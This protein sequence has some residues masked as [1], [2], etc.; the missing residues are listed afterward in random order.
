LV[1][2]LRDRD[3]VPGFFSALVRFSDG[4]ERDRRRRN[5]LDSRRDRREFR[6]AAV[7]DRA[8]VATAAR[9]A[10]DSLE[11]AVGLRDARDC[12]DEHASV[13]R[14]SRRR[15]RDAGEARSIRHARR[16]FIDGVGATV[17]RV[18]ETRAFARRARGRTIAGHA[19]P[20]DVDFG[21]GDRHRI[22]FP[23]LACPASGKNF[24][25]ERL[26]GKM[27][28]AFG[29]V[30]KTAGIRRRRRAQLDD[31]SR[32]SGRNLRSAAQSRYRLAG[33]DRAI[34]AGRG[35]V[36][37]A[38]RSGAGKFR[39]LRGGGICGVP[40]ARSSGG[41]RGG[42]RAGA[43]RVFSRATRRDGLRSHGLADDFPGA[44]TAGAIVR[45]FG[46]I[47]KARRPFTQIGGSAFQLRRPTIS[48]PAES[49]RA[50]SYV[51]R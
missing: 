39:S 7:V 8:V 43:T 49:R 18:R 6:R 44:Q 48:T 19:A 23:A 38:R 24:T 15:G 25:V 26:A 46:M 3:G 16:G 51:A 27:G 21:R 35:N 13:W 37:D 10:A 14:R 28:P 36:C 9:R 50:R 5:R 34:C 30:E 33:Y 20:S 22:F 17:R 47:R 42:T 4:V 12:R 45:E 2:C 29:G 31:E 41:G 1:D 32:G 11:C 40:V